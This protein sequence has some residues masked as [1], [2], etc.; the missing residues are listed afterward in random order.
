MDDLGLD[1]LRRELATLEAQEPLISA[2]RRHLQ[3][4]IDFGFA[5]EETRAREREISDERRQLHARIDALRERLG[6]QP[7][8]SL[9]PANDDLPFHS[10]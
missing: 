9:A 1:D 3:Q 4:Q 5:S 10:R 6:T 2:K 8:G 7:V